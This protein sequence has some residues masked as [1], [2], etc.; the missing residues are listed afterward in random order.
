[1]VTLQYGKSIPSLDDTIAFI[2]SSI[3]VL[4]IRKGYVQLKVIH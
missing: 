2:L 1:M 4:L 3:A